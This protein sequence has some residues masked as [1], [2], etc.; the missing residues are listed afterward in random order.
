[1]TPSI[2]QMVLLLPSLLLACAASP[3]ATLAAADRHQDGAV[4]ALEGKQDADSL[5]AAALL[6]GGGRDRDSW[7]LLKRAVAI[8]P[9]RADLVWLQLQSCAKQPGCDSAS[10]EHHLRTLD[11]SNGA[12]WLSS[13][14][15]AEGAHDEP[16]KEAALRAI[17][18]STRVDIYWTTL[19]AHL[20]AAAAKTREISAAEAETAI[21]GALAARAIPGYAAMT[22]SCKAERLRRPGMI[23]TCRGVAKALEGGD[24]YIT[25]MIGVA[26]AQRLWPKDSPQWRAAG[27]ERRLYQYRSK[28]WEKIDRDPRADTGVSNYLALCQSNHREQDVFRARLIQAGYD[29]DLPGR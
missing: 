9:Y 27:E 17:S 23:E 16:A 22:S 15:R 10:V 28:L 8:A 3:A 11:P 5:A 12:A 29:P 1:M 26:M 4:I 14:A 2:R 25:E 18:H 20:T 21:I 13:L 24:T 19:I 6:S 7:G